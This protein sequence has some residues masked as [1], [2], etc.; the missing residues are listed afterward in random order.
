LIS[1]VLKNGKKWRQAELNPRPTDLTSSTQPLCY[2]DL[3]IA[4]FK[5]TITGK[6]IKKILAKISRQKKI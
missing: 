2:R 5:A 1:T 3:M 4:I 6:Y